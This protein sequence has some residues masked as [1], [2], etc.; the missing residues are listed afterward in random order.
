MT[1]GKK[2]FLVGLLILSAVGGGAGVL[3]LSFFL[4]DPSAVWFGKKGVQ[5]FIVL[6]LGVNFSWLV[7]FWSG[8]KIVE[9]ADGSLNIK[10]KV[11]TWPEKVDLKE[12]NRINVG[13]E[14]VV[15]TR[16][17]DQIFE[18]IV[19]GNWRYAFAGFVVWAIWIKRSI[20]TQK[21]A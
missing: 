8:K 5:S 16:A 19:K 18:F 14:R 17:D 6:T 20:P 12:M 13:D 11:Y 9:V 3:L 7:S 15:L 10:H 4:T 21:T 1:K 2:A